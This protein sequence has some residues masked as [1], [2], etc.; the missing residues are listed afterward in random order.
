LPDHPIAFFLKRG[1]FKLVYNKHNGN[2]L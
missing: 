2:I 1:F